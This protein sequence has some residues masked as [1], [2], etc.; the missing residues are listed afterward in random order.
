MSVQQVNGDPVTLSST[1]NNGGSSIRIGSNNKITS[2][3]S[4]NPTSYV[5]VVE[6]VNTESSLS[7]GVFANDNFN[8]VGKKITDNLA[9][10]PNTF[11]LSGALRLDLINNV[12][13]IE[14]INT[15]K[16]ASAIRQNKY[17][18]YTNKFD[19]G[20][21]EQSVDSFG[22]DNIARVSR[23]FNG[24]LTFNI[25]NPVP[26]YNSYVKP[27]QQPTQPVITFRLLTENGL[28][29][30]TESNQPLSIEE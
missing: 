28:V 10:V 12:N 9:G 23:T 26:V 16:K 18:I 20:F 17:N 8:P 11:L 25:G 24:N 6:G 21:P 14:Q 3:S 13:K 27:I 1:N 19:L 29:L 4:S 5:G 2:I 7:N 22:E 15:S 30:K